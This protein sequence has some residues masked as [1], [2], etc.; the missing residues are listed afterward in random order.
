[1]KILLGCDVDPQ[2]PPVLSTRPTYDVWEANARINRLLELASNHL[3]PITW[4]IRADE[5]VRFAEGDFA[6]G[7]IYSERLWRRLVDMGHE[8]GWHMHPMS[9]SQAHSCFEF[10]PNP[11]WLWVAN[12]ALSQHFSINA[13]RTGWNYG[14]TSL[15]GALSDLGVIV[16]FSALPGN[17]AWFSLGQ[18]T[19]CVDWLRCSERAYHPSRDDYQR[20]ES[21]TLPLLEIPIAQFR[22]SLT[23]AAKRFVWRI[24]HGCCSVSGLLKKTRMLTDAWQ[25]L[26]DPRIEMWA[27]FFHPYDLSEQ[28][29]I[30]LISNIGLLRSLPGAEF[31]TATAL[32]KA[33]A[34]TDIREASAT[35]D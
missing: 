13:T 23:G 31:Y 2:L 24:R 17:I 11:S 33:I 3:P 26:P 35:P 30:N 34:Q 22:N 4:L 21:N 16:D 19:V 8:L 32:A 15:L 10:D 7:Y 9:F 14:S 27:F 12:A 5:S 29:M 18:S 28:G 6:S 25:T 20:G 1:M